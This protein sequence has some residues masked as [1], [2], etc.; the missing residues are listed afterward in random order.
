MH[1]IPGLPEGI[2]AP[3]HFDDKR[4][5][6]ESRISNYH[7]PQGSRKCWI[8][9]RQTVPFDKPVEHFP[10]PPK[11][12][13]QPEDA[14]DLNTMLGTIKTPPRFDRNGYRNSR[15]TNMKRRATV[16]ITAALT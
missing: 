16:H 3:F 5:I 4:Q 11:N 2:D 13:I 15:A 1:P 6:G 8:V 7:E 14:S 10:S 12:K 9:L